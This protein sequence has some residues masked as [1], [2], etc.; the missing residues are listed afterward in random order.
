[1]SRQP[2]YRQVLKAAAK[3]GP[4]AALEASKNRAALFERHAKD[5]ARR[6]NCKPSDQQALHYATL[7]LALESI[8]TRII[9]GKEID[10]SSLRWLSEQLD[11][12]RPPAEATNVT[13][14]VVGKDGVP[15]SELPREPDPTPP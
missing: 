5:A 15:I 6:L 12:F 13:I 1:M 9:G 3:G 7:A 10:V 2:L 14:T 8:Q 4:T 11:R